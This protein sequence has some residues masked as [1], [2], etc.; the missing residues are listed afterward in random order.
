MKAE[1]CLLSDLI[2]QRH[3]TYWFFGLLSVGGMAVLSYGYMKMP[4]LAEKCGLERLGPLDLETPGSLFSWWMAVLWLLAAVTA[5]FIFQHSRTPAFQEIVNTKNETVGGENSHPGGDA[6][7]RGG[8]RLADIWLWAGLGCLFLSIDETVRF[9][10]LLR[11]LLLMH[12]GAR[13]NDGGDFWWIGIYFLFFFGLI[14]TRLVVEMR[15]FFPAMNFFLAAM[16]FFVAAS[17]VQ[18]GAFDENDRFSPEE[19]LMLC[20]SAEMGAILLLLI[21]FAVYA[22]FLVLLDPEMTLRWL[23]E[24]WNENK[25]TGFS[26]GVGS[27][28]TPATKDDGGIG[29]K[30]GGKNDHDAQKGPAVPSEPESDDFEVATSPKKIRVTPIGNQSR[31]HET[32]SAEELA[33]LRHAAEEDS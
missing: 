27:A 22:R 32:T 16:L 24:R 31:N 11:E 29:A 1:T 26:R 18:L 2:P 19:L 9:R 25:E 10:E 28:S 7:N 3:G 8:S 12:G 17:A 6:A 5:W 13:F 23:G 15:R 33:R 21:S 20:C 4:Q 14:G 30:N